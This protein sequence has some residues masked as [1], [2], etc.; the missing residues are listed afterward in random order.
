MNLVVVCAAGA[1][2]ASAGKAIAQNQPDAG[3]LRYPDVSGEH[4]VF[5]YAND[6]WVVDRSG[7]TARPLASP[8]GA[9]AFPR[10]SPDGS[11]IVFQGNYDGDRDL[12]VAGLDGGV[13][14][15]LT[16]HPANETP[17]D[18]DADRG[19]IFHRNGRSGQARQQQLYAVSPKGG[20]PTK[21]PP[22]YGANG[23]I[24][25]DWLAY[26]P[27]QRDFRTWKRYRGGMASDVWLFNLESLESEQIT[28]WEG[29]D[30]L[31][32]WHDG[33]VYYLSDAGPEH[34]LNIWSYDPD[35]GD[36][37]QVTDY[38]DYDVKFP[39]IGPG[40]DG[41]GEIVFQNGP[42]IFLLDLRLGRAR[43]VSITI[44]GA[45]PSV[46]PRMV[47]AASQLQ[48]G[49][50]SATGKRAVVEARGD[51]W[52]IPAKAGAPRQLTDSSRYAERSPAWSP[53]GRWIAYFSDENGEYNLYVT[54]SDGKGETRRLTNTSENYFFDI[55]WS[56]DSETILFNDKAGRIHAV[57]LESG[58][59]TEIDRDEMAGRP[60]LSWS[61]DSR[62]IAYDKTDPGNLVTAVW[63][64]DTES[65]ERRQVT[66]GYFNDSDPAFANDYLYYASMRQFTSP[67]YEDVGSTFVYAG[68]EVLIA[69]PLNG[70][71]ENPML[72][73]PDEESWNED[74]ATDEEDAGDEDATDEN[75]DDDADAS[76]IDGTWSGTAT[77]LSA[78]GLPDDQLEFTMYIRRN[79][80]G[81]YVGASESQG[82]LN[83][84]DSVTFDESTGTLTTSRADGPITTTMTGMLSGE[85]LSGTWT[86]AG[87][88]SG[89]G[90]FTA[91]RTSAS[92][93]DGKI[94]DDA[95][96]GGSGDPVEIDFDGFEA[97]GMQLPVAA[98]SFN[99]L[100]TN[101]RGDL[102]Y[103]SFAQGAPPSVKLINA[104]DDEPQ[105][106][107]VVTGAA[108]V[109][110]S[111]DGKKALL[112]AGNRWKIADAR[113]GQ[114]MSEALVPRDL[115]KMLDPRE[116]WRQL[117][118]DAW[119]RHRDFFYVDNMHGVDWDAIYD[120]Y[121]RMVDDAA[122]R[123]DVSF[124]IGEMI[125][126]LNVG[127]AYYSGGDVDGQP[128]RNVGMLGVDFELAEQDGQVGYRIARI[129]KGATWD[130]DARNPL[131]HHGMDV[132]VG[133]FVTH[134]NGSRIDTSKDPWA[135]FVGTAGKDTTLTI[136]D[137]IA[138][139]DDARN[140]RDYTIK[141]LGSDQ[142]LRYRDW[143][144]QKRAH[145]DEASGGAIGYIHVPD[146]GVNGQNE[147]FRQFYGQIGKDALI[148]DDRWNGGGQIPTRFIELL[149]RPRTNYWYRRDGADWAWPYDSH[150]GPKAMLINGQAG[151]GGDMFP[152]LFR[153]NNLGKLIGRRTWGGLVGISGVP[154]LIDGGYTAVPNFGF[155]EA[156]GTWGVEGHGVD[157]DIEVMDDPTLLA[158]GQDPQLD[159]AIEHLKA[160]I[161]QRGY[162]P[163]R[164]PAPPNRRGMG[165]RD[166][167]K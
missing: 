64:Y 93:A 88:I 7:G 121:S 117:V 112:A 41:R 30:T 25:G 157:P 100:R 48:A 17:T 98:G 107:T 39:S 32:M 11:E 75:A 35:T 160:E 5:V 106:K 81:G 77:G 145:V 161:K 131:T 71:V 22:A 18:W 123:E 19:I 84:Y 26:T 33:T 60:T 162:E 141:P 12:Y 166:A 134:V 163:P 113:P 128:S 1:L 52:T 42:E 105:E 114:N 109:G 86:I 27:N 38:R 142:Y 65:G 54:Q 94:D 16:H 165:L 29:T 56:P 69:V 164:R 125:S 127:H 6:L 147:L 135:A 66:S 158:R 37:E 129:Y 58:E 62:W 104:G 44:P 73:E 116:E 68:T 14:R 4:I 13:P 51:I 89:S 146:T 47:D 53:D 149:N 43:S 57:D 126:E 8:P 103:N 90:S 31:P 95:G 45:K 137:A 67:R 50:I 78:L 108:L 87:P 92:V 122:S 110:L 76:P 79:D 83:Q 167:D 154:P 133:D 10:F 72:I 85:S 28:T 136:A 159:A 144:E 130:S 49:G 46:R 24:H 63:I 40:T 61:S 156:D 115:N 118:R 15:R 148:I 152:W 9:E 82:Q 101:D 36:R 155:Y 21:L 140:V 23:A 80:D 119:R 139:D 153:H 20:N 3:M 151:S 34:R 74:E 99:G 120:R 59:R 2:A 91:T 150:Q 102:L 132:E 138:G 55:A 96:S 97:R 143:V 124:I 70:D 111:G